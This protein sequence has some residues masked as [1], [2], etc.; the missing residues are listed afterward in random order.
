MSEVRYRKKKA[1]K[2]NV[3]K[4]WV[5]DS[6]G[7]IT[8]FSFKSLRADVLGRLTSDNLYTLEE[9]KVLVKE[10]LKYAT[11]W[12]EVEGAQLIYLLGLHRSLFPGKQKDFNYQ[13]PYSPIPNLPFD[14]SHTTGNPNPR[15][16]IGNLVEELNKSLIRMADI[17]LQQRK[18]RLLLAARLL[19]DL[20]TVEELK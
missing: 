9:C 14:F 8:N 6:D 2:P 10:M 7:N 13:F 19:E 1:G 5:F 20:E 12:V 3:P 11:V 18:E 17:L 4:Q 15:F 16:R